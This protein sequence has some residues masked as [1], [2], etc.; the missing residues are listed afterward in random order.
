[1][2]TL[3]YAIF[4]FDSLKTL[5][6][7][8][9]PIYKK[10]NCLRIVI[11]EYKRRASK[12]NLEKQPRGSLSILC[13]FQQSRGMSG[14]TTSAIKI[15]EYSGTS[16]NYEDVYEIT[17]EDRKRFHAR[18]HQNKIYVMGGVINGATSSDV[19]IISKWFVWTWN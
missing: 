13:S 16:Q 8:V 11:E 3:I 10:F 4:L 19:S 9:E 5:S 17:M 14:L 2:H 15:G 6:D 7:T 12:C 1:M 18:V